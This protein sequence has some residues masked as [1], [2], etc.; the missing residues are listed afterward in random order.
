MNNKK[1]LIGC[2]IGVILVFATTFFSK[3]NYKSLNS[4]NN[5]SN[6]SINEME[7]YI[8][9]ISSYEAKLD[10]TVISNKNENKYVLMQKY[11]KENV[12]KQEVVEPENI[13]GVQTIFKDGKVEIKNSSLNLST[14]FNNYP[15]MNENVLWLSNFIK[16]Y[17]ENS[18]KLITEENN[19]YIMSVNNNTASKYICR[20]KLYIDKNTGN[21]TKL[22]IQ[23][24]NNK[25][26]IYILYNEIKLNSLSKEEVLAIN[27]N[28]MYVKDI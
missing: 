4:G 15:F 27:L 7:N 21:P 3:S 20:K 25:T 19:E 16:E 6:K 2:V 26:S 1:F 28:N 10:V 11:N 14:I 24:E 9:N 22:L 8:L 13:K 12:A 18:E 23:D 5:I 17:A